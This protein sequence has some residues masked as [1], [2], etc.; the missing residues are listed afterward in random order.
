VQWRVG[1][2]S[3]EEQCSGCARAQVAAARK[4]VAAAP[5]LRRGGAGAREW[6]GNVA[7]CGRRKARATAAMVRTA[8]GGGR[9][10]RR[11]ATAADDNGG[12]GGG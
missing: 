4:A 2:G 5:G 3:V 11:T 7:A 12:G 6:R 10:R 8:S 1:S 9:R